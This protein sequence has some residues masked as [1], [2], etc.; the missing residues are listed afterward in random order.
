[1]GYDY[2]VNAYDENDT[3]LFSVDSGKV[4]LEDN[5]TTTISENFTAVN[6]FSRMKINVDIKKDDLS[7]VPDFKKKLWWPDP[8][9]PKEI[10]IH[11][12]VDEIVGTKVVITPD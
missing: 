9:Y 1:M 3:L 12:W 4:I 2:I 10:D 6:H 7:I 8:N 5:G 11:F